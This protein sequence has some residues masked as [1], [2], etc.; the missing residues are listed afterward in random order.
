M[1]EGLSLFDRACREIVELH[2]FFVEWYD[3]TRAEGPDFERFEKAMGEQFHMIVPDGRL[4]DRA[5]VCSYVRA[6]RRSCNGDFS[7]VVDQLQPAFESR[8][9]IVVAYVEEQSRAGTASRR[10]ASA[11]F[12]R[13]SSAP[14]GVEWQHLQE[15]W[16]QMPEH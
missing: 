7:I 11:L 1:S 6:N 12:T 8:D 14:N 3:A 2:R 4:L 9:A 16:L 5:A 10:Q 15:T 13:S